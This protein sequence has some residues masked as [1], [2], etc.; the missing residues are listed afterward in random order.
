MT[1]QEPP[2]QMMLEPLR[3]QHRAKDRISPQECHST[4]LRRWPGVSHSQLFL[5]EPP[6]SPPPQLLISPLCLLSRE[7]PQPQERMEVLYTL[8]YL[9]QFVSL[10]DKHTK[11]STAWEASWGKGRVIFYM[12]HDSWNL[13]GRSPGLLP[14]PLWWTGFPWKL[15]KWT[16]NQRLCFIT[17]KS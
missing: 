9:G 12:S 4:S 1:Q 16:E 13:V 10:L 5:E 14:S 6:T 8:C 15:R 17:A 7:S 3:L 11:G 2:P